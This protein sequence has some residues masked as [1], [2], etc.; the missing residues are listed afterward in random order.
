MDAET[1]V[2]TKDES[3]KKTMIWL[4]GGLFTV[5]LGL[6]TLASNVAA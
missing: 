3:M 6:I 5:F 2:D 4:M 1:T